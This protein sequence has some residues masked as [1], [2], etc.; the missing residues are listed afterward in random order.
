MN[1]FLK[2]GSSSFSIPSVTKQFIKLFC[3]MC[4]LLRTS[5]MRVLLGKKRERDVQNSAKL[6]LGQRLCEWGGALA[7]LSLPWVTGRT[8]HLSESLCGTSMQT[9]AEASEFPNSVQIPLSLPDDKHRSHRS[10]GF[11][12]ITQLSQWTI[13]RMWKCNYFSFSFIWGPKIKAVK[14]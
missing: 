10:A 11:C 7:T 4:F 6:K 8:S 13:K 5:F 14:S 12:I 9:G 1:T 3:V 2:K